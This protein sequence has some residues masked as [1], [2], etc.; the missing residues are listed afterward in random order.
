[1]KTLNQFFKLKPLQQCE[2]IL[3][4]FFWQ[5][6]SSYRVALSSLQNLHLRPVLHAIQGFLAGLSA[7]NKTLEANIRIYLGLWIILVVAPVSSV[8]YQFMPTAKDFSWYYHSWFTFFY[9]IGL[10]LFLLF[11]LIGIFLLFPANSRRA[12]FLIIPMGQTLAK[13]FILIT[14]TSNNDIHAIVPVRLII[15]MAVCS[16]PILFSFNYLMDRQFHKLD[17]IK[18]RIDGLGNLMKSEYSALME[19]EQKKL[20]DFQTKY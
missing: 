17:G 13:L 5:S 18:A 16:A 4:S 7:I 14:A 11:T 3:R 10:E 12:Y 15:E 6:V 8:A 9:M 1:M 2:S 20:K 19:S